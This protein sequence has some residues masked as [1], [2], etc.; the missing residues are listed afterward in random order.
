MSLLTGETDELRLLSSTYG[1]PALLAVELG[2]AELLRSW[3]LQPAA[4]I[5][6]SAGET[7]AMVLAGMVSEADAMRA[8][9]RRGRT[10]EELA[11][12]GGLLAVKLSEAETRRV[13]AEDGDSLALAAIVGPETSIISGHVQRLQRL[14]RRLD[15]R[16]VLCVDSGVPY[17]FHHPAARDLVKHVSASSPALADPMLPIYSSVVG[18]RIRHAA[19][20]D[21]HYWENALCGTLRFSD[22]ISRVLDDGIH[23]FVEVSP[24]PVFT[25]D[26]RDILHGRNISGRAVPTMRRYGDSQTHLALTL[27]SVFDA[28]CSV[29][30]THFLGATRRCVPWPEYP[31][32]PRRFWWPAGPV[33]RLERE[34]VVASEV[35]P[36]KEPQKPLPG[37]SIAYEM[38][39]VPSKVPQRARDTEGLPSP[40]D[41]D[42]AAKVLAAHPALDEYAAVEPQIEAACALYAAAA[43]RN[44]GVTL[45]SACRIEPERL[46]ERLGLD[47]PRRRLLERLCEILGSDGYLRRE[48][49]AWV[50]AREVPDVDPDLQ[51][52]LLAKSHP[53][54]T[55]ELSLLAR[56]GPR[57]GEVLSGRV[58][59]L[60]LLFPQ[61]DASEA[62]ALFGETGIA[63]VMNGIAVEAVRSLIAARRSERPLRILEIGAGTGG[64]TAAL[65]SVLEGRQVSY[66][67]TDISRT[68]LRYA[69]RRFADWPAMEVRLLD[70]A[71]DP[72]AQGFVPR[73]YDLI[74]A[75]NVLHATA[76]V[77]DSIAN[78][79]RLLAPAGSLVL[80][81]ATRAQR[82]VD[83]TFGL[84]G[85]WWGYQD[86]DLRPDHPLLSSDRWHA[87][88]R[89]GG[90]QQIRCCPRDA[91]LAER[92]QTSVFECNDGSAPERAAQERWLVIEGEEVGVELTRRAKADGQEC[93]LAGLE[94]ATQLIAEEPWD[95]IVDLRCLA[96]HSHEGWS[97][98]RLMAAQR[99]LCGGL[100]TIVR[101][102]TKR[103]IQAPPLLLFATRGAIQAGSQDAAPDVVQATLCGCISALAAEHPEWQPR[104]TDCDAGTPELIAG[105][106][107]S[108]ARGE[109]DFLQVAYREGVRLRPEL[110]RAALEDRTLRPLAPDRSYLVTG[111]LGAIGFEAAEWLVS[112]GAR[113]LILA[114]R[115]ATAPPELAERLAALGP[116]VQVEVS[117][118]DLT[119]AA[120]THTWVSGLRTHSPPIAGVIHTAGS[121]ED[122]LLANHDWPLF[123]RVLAP[124][125]V[126]AWELHRGL[127]D[128]HLELFALFGSA[129]ELLDP[130]GMANYVAANAFLQ[131]LA[132]RRRSQGL[133]GTCIAWG[134]WTDIGMARRRSRTWEKRWEKKGVRGL[135]TEASF[136]VLEC[137]IACAPALLFVMD[138]NWQQFMPAATRE[139][140]A[141][142]ADS[143]REVDGPVPGVSAA[144]VA[145]ADT[146]F[147]RIMGAA[148][149]DRA[150]VMERL[151]R[152]HALAILQ[153]AE[154]EPL[155][156]DVPLADLGF[157][158]LMS[159]ELRDALAADLAVRL[160][161]TLLF[162]YPA[163]SSLVPFLLGK[164][165]EQVS[166]AAVADEGRRRMSMQRHVN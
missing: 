117:R 48:S 141:V 36:A 51:L 144:A 50:V 42:A 30:C 112:L 104:V 111:G 81:E 152:K 39:W 121:F 137:A 7:A 8:S 13:I 162:D 53:R 24:S 136:A 95:G 29:T 6:Y 118:V 16:D 129:A 60:T 28:G 19:E 38:S 52:A 145:V 5:G 69:A 82:I 98:P 22:A 17:L 91:V 143:L 146:A 101:A 124:K 11:S 14:Q 59:P 71:N 3:G 15:S 44:V 105:Q 102:L 164:I 130:V 63:V 62:A 21:A 96:V 165:T 92:L 45:Q 87:V 97:A 40:A 43:L 114:Q 34:P 116:G 106:I 160:P 133:A 122:C 37:L 58:D 109:H 115:S 131:A 78:V 99:A 65:R 27:A 41:L 46:A 18:G 85:D 20:I 157:D 88:L 75:A 148:Q 142:M 83:L 70:I 163:L 74:V 66:V 147:E 132:A 151:V 64:T 12:A 135:D 67:F 108:E 161:A 61:S 103:S 77:R 86:M 94:R 84:T 72:I 32:E 158:S 123:E 54:L 89:G 128:L 125:V 56:C 127:A 57:V 33:T 100:L 120:A 80:I 110:R 154:H 49:A 90:F 138:V 2:L 156:R 140:R 25:T 1:Q 155:D 76:R 126:G 107:W 68:L 31:W 134:G 23:V 26:I 9:I 73:S 55:T 159:L 149:A 93:V 47:V 79:Q 10:L 139:Q 113:H 150:A 166:T 153:L 119:D 4:V 35:V